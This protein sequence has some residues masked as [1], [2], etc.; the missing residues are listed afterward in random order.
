MDAVTRRTLDKGRKNAALLI[1]PQYSPFPVEKQIAIIY[2]GTKG[3]LFD[4]PVEKIEVF[5]KEYL[6]IL[7]LKHQK[8]VLDVLKTGVI[9]EEVEKI[10]AE[11][12]AE[13]VEGVK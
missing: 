2:A 11:T 12:A 7:E 6:H 3:L 13:V 8:D 1:Q 10:L 5:E 4:L 9:T